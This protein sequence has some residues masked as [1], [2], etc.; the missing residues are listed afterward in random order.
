MRRSDHQRSL[1]VAA[2]PGRRVPTHPGRGRPARG[3]TQI[4][5]TFT[6]EIN[7]YARR[8][9]DAGGR[10]YLCGMTT[11][12]AEKLTRSGQLDL[13]DGVVLVPGGEVLGRSLREAVRQARDWLER[14]D[15]T[16]RCRAACVPRVGLLLT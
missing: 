1:T 5:P 12:L 2:A 4:G 6:D 16:E 9:A 15:G 10:L 13:G 8:L 7:G 3:S 14:Q 11:E